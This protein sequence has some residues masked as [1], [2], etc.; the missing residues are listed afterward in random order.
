M[1]VCPRCKH[2]M[3][4][5]HQVCSQCGGSIPA[6]DHATGVPSFSLG[7]AILSIVLLAASVLLVLLV[8][9]YV[10]YVNELGR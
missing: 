6:G 2:Q 4:D 7:K 9:L 10:S 3:P 5:S 8:L 1:G